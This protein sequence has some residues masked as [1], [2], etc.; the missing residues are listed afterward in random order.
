MNRSYLL[1]GGLFLLSV[2]WLASGLLGSTVDDDELIES[3]T[4][5]PGI[6]VE[7]QWMQAE[8][9]TSFITAQGN[10]LPNRIVTLRAETAGQVESVLVPEGAR[11]EAGEALLKLKPDDRLIRRE[12]ALL[13]IEEK[14]RQHE[15]TANLVE[16]GFG[17]RTELDT[18][19]VELKMAEVELAQIELE[20]ERTTIRAPFTGIL[21]ERLVEVGDYISV[22][23]DVLTVV[24][25]DPLAVNV[26][27]PQR[28]V[29]Y[30]NQGETVRVSLVEGREVEGFVRYISARADEATRTFRVEVEIPNPE[31]IR[32]GSSATAFI[33]KENIMAHFISGGLLT[34]NTDGDMGVKTVDESSVVGFYPVTI[35]FSE[36]DGM[37]VSG[38]P[39]RVR[40]ITSG[41]GFARVGE[42]VAVANQA[43]VQTEVSGNPI[44][45]GEGARN[46]KSD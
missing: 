21:D 19:L 7:A 10:V 26:S 45:D 25:N 3:M 29:H 5:V 35:E 17:S 6:I 20:I 14:K 46:A 11:V 44:S 16:R 8:P 22:G 30:I 37:W 32:A 38:L 4:D 42:R 9:I 23:N 13:K 36:T 41:Q 31:G 2:L 33:P 27:V 15:A 18:A 12:Q 43:P 40:V 34:L 39:E 1:A 24:E 28:S